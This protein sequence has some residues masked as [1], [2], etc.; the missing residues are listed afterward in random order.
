MSFRVVAPYQPTGDQPRAIELHGCSARVRCFDEGL[1]VEDWAKTADVPPRCP[2]CGGLLRPDVVWFGE[3]LAPEK[4]DAAQAAA[5]TCDLF[6]SIGR[7]GEVEPAAALPYRALRRGATL[8]VINLDVTT[9]AS[10]SIY[11][12]H[13]PAGHVLPAL[14]RAAWPDPIV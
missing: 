8:A 1:I 10:S 14:L 7:S 13:G 5:D 9:R 6:L 4:L 12:I 11:T 2:H 3:L